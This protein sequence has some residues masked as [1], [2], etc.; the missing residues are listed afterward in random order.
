MCVLCEASGQ[1][2]EFSVTSRPAHK[3]SGLW[4]HGV[5]QQLARSDLRHIIARVAAYSAT[6]TSIWK[7]PLVGLSCSGP[8]GHSCFIGVDVGE[9]PDMPADFAFL[10]VPEMDLVSTWHGPGHG[11][12][13]RRYLAMSDWLR[14]H[15]YTAIS[16]TCERR[17]EYPHDTDGSTESGLRLMIP[18]CRQFE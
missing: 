2:A 12:I 16:A 6:R 13:D 14:E 11:S 18:I 4:W 9:A 3:L 1:A 15:G 5:D 8:A 17:E 7:S 10:D